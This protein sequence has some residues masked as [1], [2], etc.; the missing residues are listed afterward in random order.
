MKNWPKYFSPKNLR[1]LYDFF[2][3]RFIYQRY[4]LFYVVENADWSIAWDGKYITRRLNQSGLIR[5]KTIVEPAGL[6]NSLVH[7][8]SEN[9]LITSKGLKKVHPSN[10][11]ILTWFHISP[12]DRRIKFI[13]R[14]NFEV[15]L[16]HTSCDITKKKLV[17]LGLKE[18][19]IIVIPL[20]VDLEKFYP[21]PPK[22]IKDIKKQL[23]LPLDKFI[24]GSFQKDGNGWGRGDT[25]KLV[26]GPDVFCDV[27]RKLAKQLP[28]H[29]LLTGPARGYVKNRLEKSKISFTHEFIKDYPQ[30]APFYSA[31]DLYLVTSR[32]EGGP[33]AILESMASG[34]PV[35]STKVGLAP[36][37]IKHGEN[38]LLADIDNREEILKNSISILKN[39][40][41]RKKIIQN[42]RKT[43][44]KF[45]WSIIA[46]NYYNKIYSPLLKK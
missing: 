26:K 40:K 45:D 31:L 36:D 8:G 6:R 38:G 3:N 28:V 41:I 14:L 22:K 5:T 35:V 11:I 13:P 44:R 37:V 46:D 19:K 9:T 29:V 33:K 20:G 10:K 4:D 15:S 27:V 30:I 2:V 34:V 17:K 25:P 42:A 18:N 12:R 43:I 21:R 16:V 23:G 24:I 7:F 32:E 1:V 39:N